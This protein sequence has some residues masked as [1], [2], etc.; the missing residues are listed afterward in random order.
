MSYKA[1]SFGDGR[2]RR[3]CGNCFVC[4]TLGGIVAPSWR[5]FPGWWRWRNVNAWM[6]GLQLFQIWTQLEL[7]NM[8]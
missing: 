3:K 6:D 1:A 7:G 4:T 5:Q 8:R 2:T